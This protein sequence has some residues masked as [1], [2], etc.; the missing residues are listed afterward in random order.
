MAEDS[1]IRDA[2]LP[3]SWTERLVKRSPIIMGHITNLVVLRA[4]EIHEVDFSCNSCIDQDVSLRKATDGCAAN[5]YFLQ[6]PSF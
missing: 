3:V 2:S 1:A 4:S 5:S 6:G